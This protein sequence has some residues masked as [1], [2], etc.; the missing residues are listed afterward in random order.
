MIVIAEDSVRFAHSG[1]SHNLLRPAIAELVSCGPL[2]GGLKPYCSCT[3]VHWTFSKGTH[4][5]ARVRGWTRLR[6]H[7]HPP[8]WKHSIKI[9]NNI[10]VYTKLIDHSASL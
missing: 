7:Y 9:G 1:P 6:N 4:D 8:Y 10:R 5:P 3:K 2:S